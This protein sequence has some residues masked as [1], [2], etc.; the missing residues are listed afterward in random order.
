MEQVK[1]DYAGATQISDYQVMMKD[2]EKLPSDG[3]SESILA[4]TTGKK[5]FMTADKKFMCIDEIGTDTYILYKGRV[6]MERN[7]V[8]MIFKKSFTP[9]SEGVTFSYD[10]C[11]EV[12]AAICKGD[13]KTVSGEYTIEEFSASA[14]MV[15]DANG[16]DVAYVSNMNINALSSEVFLNP[17][18]KEA[19]VNA[20]DNNLESFTY[21]NADGEE[22]EYLVKRSGSQ[23]VIKRY[24]ESRVIDQYGAPS[25]EHLL[26]TDVNGMDLLAR[27]MYGGRISLLVG[28]IVVFLEVLIGVI[29]G[30][31][32]GFFGGWI[33]N[34]LMRLV[35]VIYCI[36]AIPLYMILGSIMDYM[37]VSATFRIYMLCVIMGLI[38]WVGI[39]RIVRGQIL[40]LR[41]QE[42]MIAAEATGIRVSRRIFRHLIPNVIPQLIVFASMGLGDVIL[43]EASLSFLGLGIKY[44]AASWGSIINAVNDSFVMT[45]Y[46]FVWVPAGLLILLTVLAFNFIGDGLRDAF[47]PKMKR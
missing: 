35:D 2:G 3:Y 14:S 18:Y 16:K 41:E 24:Q 27:L 21:I 28:F 46:L 12:I 15:K 11:R 36:P 10:F 7:E 19:V 20:I 22:E 39:A 31:I 8:G 44:P 42:F 23:Y 1:N 40:S 32:A 5:N 33:D 34:I 38:G 13:A 6:P 17:E 9:S 30:G 26:G 45:N 4:I 25:K 29:I 37:Q 43:T 47:D